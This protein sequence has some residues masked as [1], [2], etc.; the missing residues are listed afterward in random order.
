MLMIDGCSTGAANQVGDAGCSMADQVFLCEMGA[1]NHGQFVRCVARL[2]RTWVR[3]GMVAKNKRG[4][5][6]RCAARAD[7]P[8]DGDD[9]DLRRPGRR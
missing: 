4:R 6:V 8:P 3:A 9:E 5:I 2:T 1:R 7:I